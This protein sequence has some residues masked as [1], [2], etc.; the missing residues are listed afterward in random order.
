MNRLTRQA[1]AAAALA[2]ALG[3]AAC[4]GGSD[5]DAD[6]PAGT[7]TTANTEGG[8][9][10]PVDRTETDTPDPGAGEGTTPD[11]AGEG[12]TPDASG[13]GTTP[14]VAAEPASEHEEALHLAIDAAEEAVPGTRAVDLDVDDADHTQVFIEVTDGQTTTKVTVRGG[15]ATPGETDSTDADDRAEYEA[16]TVTM[17]EAITHALAEWPGMIDEIELETDDD[18]GT[19]RWDFEI[20][21]DGRDMDVWVDATT[22]ETGLDD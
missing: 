3:L 19:L 15:V 9:R 11:P 17:Q 8:T 20:E 6:A 21:V 22:G 1:T 10:G 12:T 16:A 7:A 5:D 13:D 2:L 18:T 14:D 4:N